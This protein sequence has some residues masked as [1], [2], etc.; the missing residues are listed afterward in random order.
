MKK[1]NVFETL[2]IAALT[3]LLMVPSMLAQDAYPLSLMEQA[4]HPP[5]NYMVEVTHADLTE[6]TVNTAQTIALMNVYSNWGVELVESVLV[7][8]FED[9]DDAAHNSTTVTVGDG[10]DVDRFLASQELN[11]NGT[12]VYLKKGQTVWNAGV[13]T[14]DCTLAYGWKAFTVDDT[15]DA[16]FTPSPATNSLSQLDA[17]VIRF[18]L[19][20][21]KRQAK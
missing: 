11:I 5:A 2:A 10:D 15:I 16:V 14:N 1:L 19:K 12:Q 13:G 17:G 4:L 6:T 18:Y 3:V 7:T 21:T 8:E 9:D 20:I